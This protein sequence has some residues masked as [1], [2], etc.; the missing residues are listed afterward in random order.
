MIVL[1][2]AFVT[3]GFVFLLAGASSIIILITALAGLVCIAIAA[4]QKY[5][6]K[7]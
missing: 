3:F 4:G 1:A 5:P 7:R 2:V 6:F